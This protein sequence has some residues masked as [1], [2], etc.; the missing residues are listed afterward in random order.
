MKARSTAISMLVV[1]VGL[2]LVAV[3]CGGP[4]GDSKDGESTVLGESGETGLGTLEPAELQELCGEAQSYADAQLTQTQLRELACGHAALQAL[5]SAPEGASDEALRE[6]CAETREGCLFALAPTPLLSVACEQDVEACTARVSDLE[7]CV[8]T[9][10]RQAVQALV[11]LPSCEAITAE[12]L[13]ELDA[14]APPTEPTECQNLRTECPGLLEGSAPPSGGG[15][16]GA[17]GTHTGTPLAGAGGAPGG[18]GGA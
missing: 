1:A 15:A 4:G 18:V 13:T 17:G 16:G 14:L 11:A 7:A 3:A 5:A 9:V 8:T 10:T 2:L 6:L 12:T